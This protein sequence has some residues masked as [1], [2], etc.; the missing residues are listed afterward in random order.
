MKTPLISAGYTEERILIES[1][2]SFIAGIDEVG[3]G[4]L[5]GPVIAGAVILPP[6]PKQNWTN[7]IR[8]S[9]L[10]SSNQRIDA[11][12]K[13]I[14]HAVAYN[15]GVSSSIE[16]DRFGITKATHLA[17]NRAINGLN[18]KP[19]FLLI[20]GYPLPTSSIPQKHLIHGDSLSLSIAAASIV[21][22]VTR[23]QIM[24][25]IDIEYSLYDFKSHK[26]YG[27]KKHIQALSLHGASTI[28]RLSYKRVLPFNI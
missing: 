7:G 11:F 26:G 5:A 20:D 27:T 8:D 6:F 22:K 13:I 15:L 19:N 18:S 10:M 28:H 25:N 12:Q 14:T 17:M 4:A 21:A 1:G 23:D 9:K 24:Q 2:L 3:K 16:I